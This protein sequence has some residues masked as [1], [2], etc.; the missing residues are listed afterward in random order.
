MKNLFVVTLLAGVASIAGAQGGR[1]QQQQGPQPATL[2]VPARVWN[3]IDNAPHEGWAVLVRGE[4]IEAAGPRASLTVPA[5]ATTIDLPGT[6]LIPGLIE[7]HSHLLLHPY[8]EASWN[9]Q[10]LLEPLALRIARGT[11]H[12]RATLMA[13]FTTVRDLG[14]EGAAYAD[15][16]LKMAINQGII[17][18]PRMF[19]STKAIVS[20]GSYGPKGYANGNIA[21]EYIGMM[22]VGAE[23][24]DGVD[25][26][27]RV[28]RDQ[29]KHGADWI[30]FYADYRV[31]PNGEARPLFT[32]EEMNLIVSVASS[33][34]RPV[35]AHASTAEGM[36]R[37]T[38]AGVETIEHG[39]GGTPE[40]FKLMA[41][42]GVCFIPTVSVGN[43]S[44]KKAM[45]AKALAAGVT[46]CNG[47]DSGPLAHGDNAK[48]VQGL[49]TNG[50]SALAA[51]K[52][53]TINDAKM[54]HWEDRIGSIRP[55]LYAD[56]VAVEG[57]P[58][59]D[60]GA[61]SRVRFVMKGGTVYRRP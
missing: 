8:N 33:A 31:G 50:L 9:D 16:G 49:V 26:L 18:G 3:A 39:D 53:A 4:R 27:T 36:R 23:E 40:V 5:D 15:V 11:N 52:A 38:L 59:N 17:P 37:A 47:A 42:K 32:Q 35:A 14:T 28:V 54:L 20:T 44:G 19:T 30:K 46:I 57:D 41:E 13:G 60:I 10:V 55:G 56:L 29:I 45:L 7:G 22:P 2:L 6:T 48:E 1:G 21:T 43:R 58:T 61:L 24:A 51:M 25:G 34:G 12:A